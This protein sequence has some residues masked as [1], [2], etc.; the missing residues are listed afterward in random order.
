MSNRLRKKRVIRE[1]KKSVKE[2]VIQNIESK[3]PSIKDVLLTS[4]LAIE[5]VAMVGESL[6]DFAPFREIFTEHVEDFI[7]L[8]E[9][10]EVFTLRIPT[11][12]NFNFTGIEFIE[13]VCEGMIGSFAEATTL[14]MLKLYGST[15]GSTPVNQGMSAEPVYLIPISEWLV[16]KE[17]TV[18]GYTLNKSPF[19]GIEPMEELLFGAVKEY[20]DS[21]LDKWISEA[22]DGGIDS[23]VSNYKV[24]RR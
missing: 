23:A 4:F 2:H 16:D 18:L 22:I 12:E 17:R 15:E 3:L 20:I 8:P 1:T 11:I 13:A 9:D 24:R 21:N 19:S 5:E 10:V 6:I 14:D 7:Y